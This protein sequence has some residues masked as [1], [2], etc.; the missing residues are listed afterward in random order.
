MLGKI[1]WQKIAK[2]STATLLAVL[3]SLNPITTNQA[4]AAWGKK[5]ATDKSEIP[6]S[7]T[8]VSSKL[9]EVAPPEVIQELRQLL[10]DNKPQVSILSPRP[11]D[12]DSKC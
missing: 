9:T 5:A 3:L 2:A 6:K 11:N 1:D 12:W 10:E 8:K 7:G 4:F